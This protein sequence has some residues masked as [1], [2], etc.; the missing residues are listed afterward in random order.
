MAKA[1]KAKSFM[2]VIT[3]LLQLLLALDGCLWLFIVLPV[4]YENFM[5]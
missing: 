2:V 1:S 4:R 5:T 3:L